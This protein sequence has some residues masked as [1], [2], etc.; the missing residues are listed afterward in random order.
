MSPSTRRSG[1]GSLPGLVLLLTL[2]AVA[3]LFL[4]ACG[5]G[6]SSSSSGG[7]ST[8]GSEG[9]ASGATTAS[10]GGGEECTETTNIKM[11]ISPFQDT[12]LAKIPEALG[13]YEKACLNIEFVNLEWEAQAAA[14]AGGNIDTCI[15]NTAAVISIHEKAPNVVY[16]YPW[17]IFDE[18][19]AVMMRPDAGLKTIEEFES[20]GLDHEKAREETLKQLVGHTVVTTLNTD[21]GANLTL[22]L[23]SVGVDLDEVNIINLDFDPGLAAFLGGEGDAYYGGIPQREKA[24]KE[25]MEE[26]IVG[27]DLSPAPING[28]A[29]T[30]EFYEE[31]K[32][33]WLA[34][35]NVTFMAIRYAEKHEKEVATYITDLLNSETAGGMTTDE[36]EG[37]FQHIEH[38]PLNAGQA[39]EMI[40]EPSGIGYWKAIWDHDNKYFTEIT[41]ANKEPVPYSSFLGEQFQKEYVAKYGEDEKG[42]WKPEGS[43]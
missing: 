33:A 3:A 7:G 5:G 28:W 2:V 29:T 15:C 19:G 8:G 27:P 17:D 9:S 38:Y 4:S 37:F 42:Y 24:K 36:W 1:K 11:G 41:K 34:L 18:G 10:D 12:Y 14:L 23:E 30:E 16:L 25:G 43:L 21:V 22:A 26:M 20:E 40:F 35:Q 32:E 6:G 31:H 39:Q 13:W